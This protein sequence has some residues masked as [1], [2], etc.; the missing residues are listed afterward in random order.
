MV[1][2]EEESE[3]EVVVVFEVEVIA[4]GEVVEIVVA[5]EEAEEEL[6]AAVAV[7]QQRFAFSG[8]NTQILFHV[9]CLTVLSSFRDPNAPPLAPDIQIIG[10]EDKYMANTKSGGAALAKLSVGQ[11]MP[12]RPGFGTAGKKVM[13]YANYFKVIVPKELTL[14]RYNVEVSPQAEGKKLARVFQLLIG[15]PEFQGVATEWKS[16]I[17]SAKPLDIPDGYTVQIPY[18]AEGQDEPLARAITYTVR[19]VTPLSFSISNM[20]NYL[21]SVDP[22]PS[23]AQKLETIQVMNAVFGH[24]PQARGDV[25]SIGQNRH[26]SFDHSESNRRN[27]QILGGGL[28]SLRGY[29]QSVRPATGGLLLNVNITHGVF[30]E[31]VQLDQL[32]PKMG[33]G[34]KITLTKKM[35]RVRVRVTHIPP[36]KHKQTGQEIPRIKTIFDLAH[37]QDGRRR[38]EAH[39]P[40]V[41]HHGAGP[42][43]VK[44][45]LSDVPPAGGDP[46]PAAGKAKGKSPKQA[47]GPSLPTNTYISVFDYFKRSNLCLSGFKDNAN[48]ISRVPQYHT[49]CKSPCAQCWEPRK[50]QLSSG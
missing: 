34:N 6:V 4:V 28:E 37:P 7:P 45:W 44:F 26:F 14:T 9:L 38:D 39:P 10:I 23:F 35:K 50:S 15:L 8:K 20:V 21:A 11:Q 13:V 48:N 29:F 19:I 16:M 31:P 2:D 30:L 36:K 17:I 18:L 42:K 40:Q 33:T 1:V 27:I 3:E 32:L 47:G 24:Y 25:V 41:L 46:K 5:S 12:T 43:D 22:G 49:E